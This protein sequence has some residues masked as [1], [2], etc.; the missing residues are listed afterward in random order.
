MA[1]NCGC[2]LE[3]EPGSE[4]E[5]IGAGGV[6]ASGSEEYRATCTKPS[7]VNHALIQRVEPT[8]VAAT[9]IRPTKVG[10]APAIFL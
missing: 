10:V 3:T 4:L 8:G 5:A 7:V 1:P 6:A 2:E 9:L